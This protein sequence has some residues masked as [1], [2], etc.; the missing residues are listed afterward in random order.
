MVAMVTFYYSNGL[1]SQ[2]VLTLAAYT[3]VKTVGTQ[4]Y[5]T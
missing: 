4:A 1:L 5:G 3:H 2:V